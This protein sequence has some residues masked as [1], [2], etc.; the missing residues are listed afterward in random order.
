MLKKQQTI[1]RFPKRP[2]AVIARRNIYSRT[3]ENDTIDT[4][5]IG[6]GGETKTTTC[7]RQQKQQQNGAIAVECTRV[8]HK[9]LSDDDN[10]NES[11]CSSIS[12]SSRTDI[13]NTINNH[14]IMNNPSNNLD[15]NDDAYD[16]DDDDG[17][18]PCCCFDDYHGDEQTY[19]VHNSPSSLLSRNDMIVRGEGSSAAESG[20]NTDQDYSPSTI[21]SPSPSRDGISVGGSG[22]RRGS[23]SRHHRRFSATSA[24]TV[25]SRLAKSRNSIMSQ[26]KVILHEI[27]HTRVI[28]VIV[29][30]NA[31]CWLPL[32]F[33]N[34]ADA[35]GNRHLVTPVLI[36]ASEMAFL[37]NSLVMPYIYAFCKH[38]FKRVFAKMLKDNCPCSKGRRRRR[39][40]RR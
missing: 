3:S 16:D 40:S 2:S 24:V 1:G 32:I 5:Y 17:D 34:F 18:Y 26:A 27:K 13:K 38:D 33:L 25:T 11:S 14:L 8:H 10:G 15:D 12:N 31:F 37:L 19:L 23:R 30:I 22:G 21:A 39:L 29:L 36:L 35:T 28:A 6:G 20:D 9:I 7:Q 4:D